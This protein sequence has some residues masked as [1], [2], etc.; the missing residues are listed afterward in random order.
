MLP[1]GR[2]VLELS[3]PDA[4]NSGMSSDAAAIFEQAT[5]LSDAEC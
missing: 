5:Q 3:L 2:L 4:Y 1:N